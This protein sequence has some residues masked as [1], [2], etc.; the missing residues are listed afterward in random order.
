MIW[1]WITW[2]VNRSKFFSG[3]FWYSHDG[4]H[5]F[6]HFTFARLWIHL[7]SLDFPFCLRNFFIPLC[8]M[9]ISL[10][11]CPQV[12]AFYNRPKSFSLFFRNKLCY[13]LEV[14][15]PIKWKGHS[16]SLASI[17]YKRLPLVGQQK[18]CL[19]QDLCI[20][21][22]FHRLWINRCLLSQY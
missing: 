22:I 19:V 8:S 6:R 14:N 11:F 3:T 12:T 15:F 10:S 17:C 21:D 7:V 1:L 18:V 5:H 4:N 13:I 16:S 2:L 20:S 9:Q